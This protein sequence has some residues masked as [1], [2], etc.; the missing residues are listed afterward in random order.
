MH[1]GNPVAWRN[2]G[3]RAGHQPHHG[4][5]AEAG[6][7]HAPGVDLGLGMPRRDESQRGVAGARFV[8]VAGFA[9][10]LRER[11]GGTREQR[12]VLQSTLPRRQPS[13]EAA[14]F[15]RVAQLLALTVA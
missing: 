11:V 15:A 2:A 7:L 8:E 4:V 5:L 3:L 13:V 1:G 14:A 10:A 12:R 9:D 6:A